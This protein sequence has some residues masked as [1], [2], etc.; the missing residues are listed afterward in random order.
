MSDPLL[1]RLSGLEDVAAALSTSH[2]ISG[3]Q[4][5]ANRNVRELMAEV[6]DWSPALGIEELRGKVAGIK[7]EL[8]TLV[9]LVESLLPPDQ[10]PAA[11]E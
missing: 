6:I 1:L 7:E 8:D 3:A 2:G 4:V 9:S 10:E 5:R 11:G